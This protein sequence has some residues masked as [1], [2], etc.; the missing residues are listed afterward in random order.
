LQYTGN[1]TTLIFKFRELR[2]TPAAETPRVRIDSLTRTTPVIYIYIHTIYSVSRYQRLDDVPS[3]CPCDWQMGGKKDHKT[4][5]A[6]KAG[7]A[8]CGRDSDV[9]SETSVMSG[10]SSE[11]RRLAQTREQLREPDEDALRMSLQH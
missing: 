11:K 1:K 3:D 10:T 7:T 9:E 6:D 2:T 5:R 8:A 4:G